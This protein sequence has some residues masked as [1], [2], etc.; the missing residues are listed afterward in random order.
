MHTTCT[1]HD[2]LIIIII[3][4]LPSDFRVAYAANISEHLPTQPW[5]YRHKVQTT[6]PRTTSPTLC[7]QWV[8][9]LTSHRV[10]YEQGLW[11][12][13][14]GLS[15]LSE[16]TRKSNHLQMSLQRQHFLLVTTTCTQHAHNMTTT[17]TPHDHNMHTSWPPHAHLMTTS[18]PQHAHNMHTTWPQHA[19]NMTTTWPQHAHLM[20][21]TCT[22]RESCV[23]ITVK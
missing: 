21:T 16:K 15:S 17:C 10:I 23:A 6:T 22:L 18:W 14:S 19:H 4:Y 5:D 8:G 9:S 12:G 7:E 3:L 20:T 11:D 13:T 1:P 2:H